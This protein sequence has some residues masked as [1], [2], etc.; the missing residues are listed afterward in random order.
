MSRQ[1]TSSTSPDEVLV[2]ACLRVE[3]SPGLPGDKS[4]SH[5]ALLFSL[6][7]SGSGA[8]RGISLAEDVLSSRRAVEALG[9]SIAQGSTLSDL[10][11]EG[12]WSLNRPQ[13]TQILERHE[14][15]A[16][17]DCGN[18]GTT[19]RLLAGILAGR[20]GSVELTGDDSLSTRPMLRVVDPLQAMGAAIES[21]GGHAPIRIRGASLH[22]GTF[23]LPIAS[24]QVKSALLL[25]GLQSNGE[26]VVVEPGPSRDHTERLLS[27]MNAPI[28]LSTNRSRVSSGHLQMCDID[29][30]I[31]PSAAAFFA[32]A[33]A[34]LP[35]SSLRMDG[36]GSNPT[37]TA[38]FDLLEQFGARVSFLDEV[39][40]S[41]EPR[42][43]LAVTAGDR[44]PLT[45]GADSIPGAVD[46]LP[47]IAVLGAMAEGET[48]VTGA[49]ELRVKE[50][51]RISVLISGL[52][53][54]GVEA[55]ELPDGFVV[56]GGPRPK[57]GATVDSAGD[58]RMAMAFAVLALAA[59]EPVT[60]RGAS[61]VSVSHPSF[62]EDL[63]SVTVR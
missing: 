25:A 53:A 50:S 61:C 52:R 1:S 2:S 47:L 10:Q 18:S 19:I 62:F 17:V 9:G 57:G 46:E 49:H 41:G 23:T 20:A 15:F 40:L 13:P 43:T 29:I 44:R 38:F 58:H 24:A 27:A 36:V 22:G 11:V 28:E 5:R 7:A 6:L 35:G 37:R 16:Q 12:Y 26:T 32:T 14:V 55:E 33:A 39:T 30:P 51:D 45:I 34:I 21:N 60:I 8:V 63:S 3:G 54:L 31:D 59:E 4:I 48:V 42:A 56:R